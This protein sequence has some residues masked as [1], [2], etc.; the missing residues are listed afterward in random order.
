[1][2]TFKK[3]LACFLVVAMFLTAAPLS[4]F[5]GLQ[6]PDLNLPEI[7]FGN[8]F[9]KNAEAATTVASGYC[10]PN[11]TYI[12][13]SA[14]TL[15]IDGTSI[16]WSY[17]S[18]SD[19][20]WY[21]NRSAIKKVVIADGVT[22][23]GDHAFDDC[24][25]LVSITIPDS[26]TSIGD[27]AFYY[28]TSLASV[29][30][31]KNSQ[32]TSIEW[33]AFYKCISLASITIPDGVTRIDSY[34]FYYCT[35]LASITIPDGV[36]SIGSYAFYYCTNLA[37]II[38][39]DSVT[40]IRDYAFYYCT[41]LASVTF[42]KNSQLTSI[43]SYAFYYCFDLESVTIPDSV[44]SIGDYAFYGCDSLASIAIPDSVTSIGDYAFY[45]CDS[46]ASIAI[47]DSVTSIGDYAFQ[48]CSNLANI[49]FGKNSQLTS[50]G[51]YA[52]YDC[53]SLAI[54]AIPA[55]VTNIG[56]L[57]FHCC[58]NITVDSGSKSYCNDVD[59]VL[60]N[61]DKTILVRYPFDNTRTNYTIP[62]SV[63][64]IGNYAFYSC[65][66]LASIT[67]PN[68][69]TSIGDYAFY[70]C[71]SL[72]SITIPNSVTSIGDS[73]FRYCHSLASITIPDSVTSIGDSAFSG[74]ASLASITIPN[75][76]T[77]IGSSAFKDCASLA[78]ITI[79]DSVTR[80]GDDAF[81]NCD[82]L[83]SVYYG[84][85]EEE[86]NAISIGTFNFSLHNALIHFNCSSFAIIASG[87]CGNNIKW[88][89]DV[90]GTLK[91][92]GTEAMTNYKYS[93]DVPWSS[94]RESIKT[95]VIEDG[96]TTI[97]DY[98]FYS[99]DRL[100]SITIPNS[101]KRI[102]NSAFRYCYRLANITVDADNT[103]YSSDEYG[104][105]FNKN[106]TTLI[107]YPT[108]NARTSYAIPYSVTT[109]G[110]YAFYS[111]DR[112]ASVDFGENSQL[113]SIG[114]Y[115]FYSCTSLASITIPDS[116]TSI[117]DDAFSSCT[118]LAS[119]TIP[120][121][122]TSIGNSA[123]SGCTKLTSVTIPDSVTSIGDAAFS[124]CTSLTS[125]TIPDS[126]TSIG[127]YA[128]YHC[129]SLTSV[130]IGD[131]VTSIGYRA[132]YGCTKLTS[133]TIPDSVTSIGDDAFYDCTSL[134]SVTIG[135]SVKSIGEYAF[136]SCD[137]LT[138]VTIGNSVKSI[139]E[140][141]FY[142]CDSLTSVTI[143]NSVKSIGEYAFAYCD[144]LTSVT[145]GNSV[146][147]IGEYAFEYCDSL[148]EIIIENKD[149]QIYDSSNTI[150]ANAVIRGHDDSTA[151]SYA[152]EYNRDFVSIDGAGSD[153]IL[154]G[155][156]GDN[157]DFTLTRGGTLH[158]TGTGAVYS[159]NPSTA[160][161]WHKY[162]GFI[163][164]VIIDDGITKI[165]NYAFSQ[166]YNLLSVTIPDSVTIIG[167]SAFEYCKSLTSVII[168]DSVTSIG[169]YAFRY[170]TSLTS[171]TIPDSVTSIGDLA[172]LDCT[173]L[174]DIT[175]DA[176]N[177]TYCS[178]DGVL[179]NKSKT[180]LIQYPVGNARTSYTIPSSVTSIG[181]WA[182]DG[183]SSLTSV[184]IPDS[185][186]SIERSAF[187]YCT[188]LT[189]V[190]I[191]DSVTSI[192]DYVFYICTSLTS[193]TIP[194]SVTSIGD[195][196][197][198]IC[199]SLTSVTIP[200]SVT[201][202]GD[203]A[204][205]DCD[206]LASV[207]I[208]DSV[209]SIG[210]SAFSW[211]TSLASVTI[212][213]SV[214]SIG[215]SAFSSCDSL[216]SVTIPDSVT[217][218]G[219]SAFSWC[220]SLASVTIP[221]SVT[222]IGY[223]AFWVCTKLTSVTILNPACEIY[224]SANTIYSGATIYGYNDST[225]ETYAT[226]Y[227]RTFVSL[228]DAPHTHSYTSSITLAATCCTTGVM[229]YT[230]ECEDSYTEVI[231]FDMNNH[232]SG[233]EIRDAVDS[234]C[235][236]EGYTGDTYCLGCNNKIANG[237]PITAPGHDY[238]SVV[239]APTCEDGGY[240]T[241]T[242]T[243][244][245]DTY[246][247]DETDFLGHAYVGAV[248]LEPTCT[249]PGVKTY[250][251]QNDPSHTFKEEIPAPGHT[252]DIDAT[253]TTD[254]TCS[255][256]GA[257]ITPAT[258]HTPGEAVMEDKIEANCTVDG[259]YNMVVYC[260]IC[261]EKLST[262][263]YTITAPGHDYSTVVTDPTC[264]QD[265]YTTYTCVKC[266]YNYT[267]N[268]TPAPGHNWDSGVV[269]VSPTCTTEGIR[270]FSCLRC[271]NKKTESVAIDSTSHTGA[272]EI[273]NAVL[274]TP[275]QAG[276]SGDKHCSAC[277]AI[278]EAG[279]V[280]TLGD[281]NADGKI[282]PEDARLI[283][284]NAVELTE[285]DEKQTL[286]AD[287]DGDGIITA[288]DARLLLRATNGSEEWA[289][290]LT[291]YEIMPEYSGASR[292]VTIETDR[293]IDSYNCIAVDVYLNECVDLT[294]YQLKFTYDADC[295]NIMSVA[296]GTDAKNVTLYCESERNAITTEHNKN[297]D[298]TGHFGGYFKD[299]LWE[300][301]KFLEN[302]NINGDCIVNSEK[303]HL[304]T[305][306]LQ[307]ENAYYCKGGS[308]SVTGN[309]T[310]E[311]ANGT[312]ETSGTEDAIIS[313]GGGHYYGWGNC[314]AGTKTCSYCGVTYTY[315]EGNHDWS[316]WTER[317]PATTTSEGEEFRTCQRCGEEETRVIDIIPEEP[318]EPPTEPC[319]PGNHWG[320]W[321]ECR[322]GTRTC[323][324]CGA[325]YNLYNEFHTWGYWTIR[326]PSTFDTA[327]EQVCFCDA[328]N[329][330]TTR[331]LPLLSEGLVIMENDFANAVIADFFVKFSADGFAVVPVG[332]SVA[333][334]L[335]YTNGTAVLDKNGNM[336]SADSVLGTGMQLVLLDGATVVDSMEIAVLGD[337]D[338]DGELTAGDA[339]IALRI[340]VGLDNPE[341]VYLLATKV[342]DMI[343]VTAGDAR[344]LLR[345]SVG[346]ENPRSWFDKF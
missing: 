106:K 143:G 55:N 286:M 26:V 85:N 88:T 307:V 231:P 323:H 41:N 176:D 238:T 230:C 66:S 36:T 137:S 345:A 112:L 214:T 172:F 31:G 240:T 136:Y 245:G 10:G 33:Y 69:V 159:Y 263:A 175:V 342:N 285:F 171:V 313:M 83:T 310:F 315:Y 189:S 331:A 190:T 27:C 104:V 87:K 210:N 256:C 279:F 216:A 13:D 320:G 198:Y 253:C 197:F 290:D 54:I 223:N 64:N 52:F 269:T 297:T 63:T 258:G 132:F 179:F 327:G 278:L 246:V 242:C 71:D 75:S 215:N 153:I 288:S 65:D 70:S 249:D 291:D 165:G 5:V 53:D 48:F 205:Y 298:G 45:G 103:S 293:V 185:V 109:I 15:T 272:T 174:T 150:P 72:A 124:D 68:S 113:T 37:S 6:W 152:E 7:N 268:A 274:A 93:H 16:I 177:T 304:A 241:Y 259:S 340:S 337:A 191:P 77:S 341:E 90:E 61:I 74:C 167:D 282:T 142:S 229:T 100:A 28:C 122:V 59:G 162:C 200:D 43:G 209:T 271:T 222:S 237:D 114:D 199:T 95:V 300:A 319:P 151:Q 147:S 193:V 339:R 161:P 207:T 264:T 25:S 14:G 111:C 204:F 308:F 168:P 334:L 283:L 98:A 248:T 108:G 234:T 2:K 328:C 80:I 311:T 173:S 338:G 276:Y 91:I 148:G 292:F 101:V 156:C 254:Q 50:I 32:L 332:T 333:D 299:S 86:W 128:F 125:V 57:A 303:F 79:P 44:T 219:N 187:A 138:S 270:T 73:A 188:S 116:V 336:M 22:S 123:F 120:D 318:T 8:A 280:V 105:L 110:D 273:R 251:C 265:G 134:T 233:T 102:S 324:Y 343:T 21:S 127:D 306:Y 235:S 182:F 295:F 260:E 183:C 314:P 133:V 296:A 169:D 277:G 81:Y 163:R 206:S 46:L 252:P 227:N 140:Y 164:T 144:S 4:G 82:K 192:G 121:S 35:N 202:I 211:C 194:D 261:S 186:T 178:E 255:V 12:L 335:N 96:V 107:Q 141:A 221:D 118:S 284:R 42:G 130:T 146:T 117:G 84:S 139:G 56:D 17:S 131:S 275:T 262:T 180:E 247:A 220:D 305:I 3:A 236:L 218:I 225:T 149:C 294:S 19:V 281:V 38:I 325:K 217:S 60:F 224:D 78:S 145:I 287:I 239:T 309:L 301:D 11:V 89:L 39:P 157:A 346:L 76:V 257:M 34:A 226:K 302:S 316:V 321:G 24:Y 20:P 203:Y 115:A 160:R 244:C 201:S 58:A 312:A 51:D 266:Q 97:G 250:V 30:F 49:T 126:V 166:F 29:Y 184:T 243:V 94:N 289:Y 40:S 181:D 212:P 47:P 155:Y 129:T 119:I 344:L 228:G 92:S 9:N 1:M 322:Y 154:S 18:S 158:I 267:A 329:E 208:P 317:I 232:T 196:V 213:D 170:C 326:T 62:D 67:I 330:E 23:I 99:C 195:Y 135:N